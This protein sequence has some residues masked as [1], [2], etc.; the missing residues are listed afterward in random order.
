MA[1]SPKE[2]F[3]RQLDSFRQEV[4]DVA[5]AFYALEGLYQEYFKPDIAAA[6]DTSADFWSAIALSLSNAYFMG[7]GRIFD[8]KSNYNVGKLLR[9]AH[10]YFRSEV[11]GQSLTNFSQDAMKSLLKEIKSEVKSLR[12]MYTDTHEDVRNSWVA[13]REKERHSVREIFANISR[14]IQ[15]DMV[16]RLSKII[17]ALDSLHQGQMRTIG[18]IN[19][20]PPVQLTIRRQAQEFFE[21]LNSQRQ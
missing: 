17:T 15:S 11:S 16:C 1:S 13:H 18:E 5:G 20:I 12:K 19:Y 21:R 14:Q 10:T 3:E 9:T 8:H 6:L 4:L 2:D 7:I